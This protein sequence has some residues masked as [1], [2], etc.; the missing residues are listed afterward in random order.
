MSKKGIYHVHEDHDD[1]PLE[2]G[3]PH[4]THWLRI[5][6]DAQY[7][8]QMIVEYCRCHIYMPF[9]VLSGSSNPRSRIMVIERPPYLWLLVVQKVKIE[10]PYYWGWSLFVCVCVIPL[11]LHSILQC[12]IKNGD[13]LVPNL[14]FCLVNQPPTDS[15]NHPIWAGWHGMKSSGEH[16]G[17][18]ETWSNKH[19]SFGQEKTWDCEGKR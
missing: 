19:R 17:D 8:Y 16:S 1:K 12:P 18:I 15:L 13:R 10:T 2:L 6:M 11:Y 14:H 4:I 7:L 3:P 5:S 9:T